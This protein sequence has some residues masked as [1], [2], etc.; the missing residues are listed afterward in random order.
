MI[1]RLRHIPEKD[2]DKALRQKLLHL[3][4]DEILQEVKNTRNIG[5]LQIQV[6]LVDVSHRISETLAGKALCLKPRGLEKLLLKEPKRA[7]PMA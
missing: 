5:V 1:D 7:E 4:M 2:L 3:H 6:E